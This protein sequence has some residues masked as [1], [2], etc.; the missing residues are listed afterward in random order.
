MSPRLPAAARVMADQAASAALLNC[1]LKEFALPLSLLDQD[2]QRQP[3][4]LP[5][6]LYRRL[7]SPRTVPLLVRMPDGARFAV[8]ADRDDTLGS[9][10]YVSAVYGQRPGQRWQALTPALLAESMLDSCAA[11]TGQNNPELLTQILASR[12]LKRAVAAHFD[13]QAVAPL[14]EYLRSEQ[15]LWYGHPAQVAPKAR[16]WPAAL[17]QEEVSPEFG[18]ALRLHLFEVPAGGLWIAAN[19]MAR[20]DVLAACADQSG[21]RPGHAILSMHPVQAELFRA[22]PRVQR[23]QARQEIRDLGRSG[24][25]SHPTASVRTMY[26]PGHEYFIKGS[27][28]IRITNCVRKNAWYE[29]ESA[30]LIDSLLKRL[31]SASPDSTG[32][33]HT[34]SEPAALG[35]SPAGHSEEDRIWFREQTGAILRTNFCLAEGEENCLLAGTVFGRDLALQSNVLAFLEQ[36]LGRAPEADDLLRWFASY[37]ALLLRPVLN[38][39]FN[40]GVIFEPHLQNTV[41]VHRDGH[42]A[43]LLLRDYEGVKLS[44]ELGIH[45]VPHDIPARVRQSM[46]YPRAQGWSRIAY[47][48][49]VNNLSEAVLA[50]THGRPALA[51]A[52]WQLVRQELAQ[53]RSTLQTPAPELDALLDDASIPCKTNFRIR[54]AAAADKFAGYV[55]LRAPW[56]VRP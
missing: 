9:Q 16:L 42:P 33:L 6:Q 51:P 20:E 28:N 32:G 15:C 1:L 8:L 22:D 27:L 21:A 47:C 54:L 14:A 41:L 10:T 48:L 55:Q 50:L 29:L 43:R 7:Q 23:L 34:V 35:W 36:Q 11:V 12:D 53:I 39:F 18:A 44:A 38:M 45:A 17:R 3:L 37:A 26:I 52:M 25:L 30:L 40:H 2:S 5:F 49:F 19:G 46:E 31:T 24:F 56:Q 4:G 13:D